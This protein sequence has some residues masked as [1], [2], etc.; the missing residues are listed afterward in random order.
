MITGNLHRYSLTAVLTL[1]LL[2]DQG[3][4]RV[5]L[6]WPTEVRIAKLRNVREGTVKR[7]DGVNYKELTLDWEQRVFP[8]ETVQVLGPSAPHEIEYEYDHDI[9]RSRHA[10][11]R[12][13]RYTLFFEDHTPISGA[14]P[15]GELNCF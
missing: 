10:R 7:V 13:L 15:F 11:P 4:L 3:K 12:E 6:L 8:G 5:R 1:L 14:K 9:F 2:P